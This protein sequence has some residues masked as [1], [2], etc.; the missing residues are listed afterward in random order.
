[1]EATLVPFGA[2]APHPT[3]VV[4]I[5]PDDFSYDDE[6]QVNVMADG[7]LWADTPV[8]AS[9]TATNNDTQPGVPPDEDSDPY[10]IP[11]DQVK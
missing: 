8:A 2:Q 1:M 10:A 11:C 4:I 5:N 9:S 6:R 7:R 3:H